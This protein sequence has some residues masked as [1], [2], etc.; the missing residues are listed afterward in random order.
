M[1]TPNLV[2]KYFQASLLLFFFV[3]TF[4]IQ[5]AFGHHPFLMDDS[6]QVS[7]WQS[8]F[9]G[10]AHPLLGPD[11]LLFILGIGLV[12]LTK[13]KKSILPLL[14]VG[15]GGSLLVQLQP[16]PDFLTPWAEAL[17]SL[18]LAIEGL[19]ALNFLSTKWLLPMFALHGYLL[20][21]TIVGAEPSPLIGYFGGLLFVQ[22]SL[23][24]V[25]TSAS[26]KVFHKLLRA[27]DRI[28]LAGIWIGIGLAFSWVALIE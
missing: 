12:G 7:V 13:S 1:I 15:L 3:L 21:S 25:V 22:G 9:S 11:H 8:L 17:V 2:S 27:K 19:I 14:A 18:S 20:G 4:F 28:T 5:P 26:Q 10:I 24:L 6:Y 23:L 16:L